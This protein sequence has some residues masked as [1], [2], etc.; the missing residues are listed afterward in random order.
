MN[1]AFEVGSR[2]LVSVIPMGRRIPTVETHVK[3][4]PGS[5]WE[6]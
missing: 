5:A 1:V 3:A 4:M 2:F 6:G